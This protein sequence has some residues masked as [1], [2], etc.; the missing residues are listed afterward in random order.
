MSL[1]KKSFFNALRATPLPMPDIVIDV[2][3]QLCRHDE[4]IKQDVMEVEA[5]GAAVVDEAPV[6]QE[7]EDVRDM[8]GAPTQREH[9]DAIVEDAQGTITDRHLTTDQLFDDALELTPVEDSGSGIDTLNNIMRVPELALG[10]DTWPDSTDEGA[11]DDSSPDALVGVEEQSDE[12]HLPEDLQ[13]EPVWVPR[14]SERIANKKAFRMSSGDHLLERKVH[15]FRV[16]TEKALGPRTEDAKRVAQILRLTI[17]KAMAKNPGATVA[18][19][20]KEFKQLLDKDVWTIM[21]KANLTRFQLRS[22]I[23]SSMFLKEKFDAAGVFDKL[24]ARLV[25]G[26]DGQDREQFDNLSCPTVTQETVM[27]VLAIAAVERRKLMTID[28]T[29]AY[30]ECDL[31]DEMEVIMKLDPLLTR[32]LHEVDKSAIG[33]EDE[34]GV[35]YVK[36]NKAL[37]GTVQAALLWYK[38]LSGVLLTDG[39]SANPY[40]ACLFNKTV[41]G[42]QITVCFHVD[43]LLVTCTSDALMEDMVSHLSSN[44]TNLTVNRGEQHSYLAMNI[45]EG[46]KDISVDMSAYIDKCIEGR[47]FGRAAT[48]PAKDDLFDEPEDSASLDDTDRARFHSSV[49]QLLYLCKRTRVESLCAVSHLSSRVAKCTEDDEV[50]LDRVLNYLAHTRDRKMVMKKGGIVDM[51]AYIDASFGSHVDGRSRTGIALMMCGVC[52]GAWSAKQKLN[53]KSS[54]EAEIVG[55]SDGLSHVI[56]MREL[57]LAQGYDLP[58]TKVHQ[59]NQGVLS[60]MREGRS[61][62]HRTK[63]LNIRHFFARDRVNSGDITLNYC[64]TRE[65][66][67]DVLTKAVNGELFQYLISLF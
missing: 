23:R 5:V 20:Q 9:Q 28:I 6:A 46:E 25:A 26:G 29:G 56:W 63:H 2:L 49:A 34:K 51:E 43:D 19:V 40:D 27:M 44:F 36:L 10:Q 3:N 67:A 22:A 62:K 57:L 33:K 11:T 41:E 17:K 47:V 61:P 45:V 50:K 32:I 39:F 31:T 16:K 15:I 4:G 1:K 60:I 13:Q 55:L 24:K 30:L 8:V 59:D 37:Y 64:P 58:P 65:M 42:V 7:D 48:S 66:V 38:K 53:T 52:V 21:S 18:S 54:T 35:T 12:E 14:R